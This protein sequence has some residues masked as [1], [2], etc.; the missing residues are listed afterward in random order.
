MKKWLLCL[1]LFPVLFSLLAAYLASSD[2]VPMMISAN[3]ASLWLVVN[4][5]IC[6]IGMPFLQSRLS[7]L[8]WWHFLLFTGSNMLGGVT[9]F[10]AYLLLTGQRDPEGDLLA[11]LEPIAAGV[12]TLLACVAAWLISRKKEK[13]GA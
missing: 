6:P 1:P 4:L 9:Y 12:I 7:E 3:I 13:R 10:G 5:Q 8:K 2:S 11:V